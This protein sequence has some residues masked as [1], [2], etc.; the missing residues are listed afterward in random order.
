VTLGV[1][2]YEVHALALQHRDLVLVALGLAEQRD[3]VIRCGRAG[4]TGYVPRSATSLELYEALLTIGSGRL[5][6]SAEISCSLMRALFCAESHV[7]A[8]GDS[9]HP[10]DPALTQRESEVLQMI[11]Q[12]LSNKEIARELS[13]SVATVKHHVHHVLEKLDLPCRAR[14]MRRVRDAPWLAPAPW[15]AK[16][17]PHPCASEETPPR[18]ADAK[19]AAG[20]W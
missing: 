17:G 3:D 8:R 6:C 18:P 20:G 13:I 12:G 7:D 10:D 2:L 1:D 11:G 5:T 4:F 9:R 19:P 14:A 16:L 15:S